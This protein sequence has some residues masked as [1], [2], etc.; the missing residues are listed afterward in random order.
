[1]LKEEFLIY[2]T[3]LPQVKEEMMT[4][5][6]LQ[7]IELKYLGNINLHLKDYRHLYDK[8]LDLIKREPHPKKLLVHILDNY[9]E[10]LE[11]MPAVDLSVNNIDKLDEQTREK[12]K[13]LIL[14]GT[15]AAL[16]KEN[17]D[18]QKNLRRINENY[19]D[20]MSIVTHEFKNS[21]TSIYGYNR[22]IKKKAKA[23]TVENVEEISD[24]IDRLSRSLFSL[25]ETLFSMALIEEGKL[26]IDRKIFDIVQ[27]AINPVLRDME[28]RLYQKKIKIKLI[29]DEEKNI[30]YG[31][32]KFFQLIFRNL[33]QNAV[34]YGNENSDI[35][36]TIHR[37]EHH[38]GITVFNR[39]PG[40]SADKLNQI[41]DKFSRFH[42]TLDKTNVGIG[43]FAVK[44]IIELH[45]GSIR[46][47]SK[48]GEW[49]RFI[50][51]LPFNF[52]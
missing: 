39:G 27:D 45:K 34:Q 17:S 8:G 5:E 15:Q 38:L 4:D 31:D 29:L 1:M 44:N 13:A 23:G 21:L 30:Y 52:K 47:E 48:T 49:M 33:I 24:N 40:I 37:H 20:L 6:E 18:I 14:F 25:M 9:L 11:D 26:E 2:E 10:K 36:I 50:I 43:L 19:K 32:E 12:V 46:A 42:S 3:D 35:E 28:S 7:E 22:I 51:E 16:I 41:F